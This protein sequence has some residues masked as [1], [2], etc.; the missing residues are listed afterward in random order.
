MRIRRPG[1]G[2]VDSALEAE[3]DGGYPDYRMGSL[4]VNKQVFYVVFG[5]MYFAVLVAVVVGVALLSQR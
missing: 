3:Y 4:R 1:H 5:I 2:D